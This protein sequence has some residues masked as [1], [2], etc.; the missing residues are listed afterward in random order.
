MCHLPQIFILLE[1]MV[2]THLEAMCCIFY[3]RRLYCLS[4]SLHLSWN[5]VHS[6][7]A[8]LN[9]LFILIEHCLHLLLFFFPF[10]LISRATEKGFMLGC[11][12]KVWFLRTGSR[13]QNWLPSVVPV[14]VL[15]FQVRAYQKLAEGDVNVGAQL[16]ISTDGHLRSEGHFL[17]ELELRIQSK[18]QT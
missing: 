7:A 1:S 10:N 14:I 16:T 6:T 15:L 3:C 12:C 5:A 2:T 8:F 11:L 18:E 9:E 13:E 17:L 4:R